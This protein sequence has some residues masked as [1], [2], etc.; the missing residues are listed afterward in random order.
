MK[1]LKYILCK[2]VVPLTT[3]IIAH[4]VIFYVNYFLM[5]II[6]I[7]ASWI[8]PVLLTTVIVISAILNSIDRIN[9]RFYHWF[10]GIPINFFL[11]E[12]HLDVFSKTNREGLADLIIVVSFVYVIFSLSFEIITFFVIKA[13]RH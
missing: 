4:I 2:Q 3:V 8:L 7:S 6:H 11:L 1:V 12:L 5:F 13:I 9:I 10:T